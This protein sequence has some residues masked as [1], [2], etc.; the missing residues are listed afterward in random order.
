MLT[1]RLGAGFRPTVELGLFRQRQARPKLFVNGIFFDPIVAGELWSG[2]D[3]Y[4]RC[5]TPQIKSLDVR[6]LHDFAS[7]RLLLLLH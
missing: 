2:V 1:V 7:K 4:E 5:H 3:A 6:A